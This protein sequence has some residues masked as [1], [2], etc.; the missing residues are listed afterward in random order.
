MPAPT[1]VEVLPPTKSAPRSGVRWT[2]S[3]P[4]AGVLVIEKPRVVATY[5]VT[6][7][8]TPW[9]GRAFRLVC[10]GGQSDADATTYDVFAARNGQDHRCDCKGFS[11]GRGRPCKHVA[12]ALALLENGWI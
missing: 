10:L 12:A 1:F 5:A 11:Y 2:P 6:E 9:D 7:F 3:G 4:G 8:G